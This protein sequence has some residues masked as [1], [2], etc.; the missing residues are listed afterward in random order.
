MKYASSVTLKVH[1]QNFQSFEFK[2]ERKYTQL[3]YF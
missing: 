2:K 3:E 1:T